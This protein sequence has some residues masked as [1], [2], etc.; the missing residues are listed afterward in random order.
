MCQCMYSAVL[1]LDMVSAFLFLFVQFR[2][3][4]SFNKVVGLR[5]DGIVDAP[6]KQL[7]MVC[8]EMFPIG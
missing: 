2:R 4:C 1:L 8:T 7:W 5:E 3:R 6:L